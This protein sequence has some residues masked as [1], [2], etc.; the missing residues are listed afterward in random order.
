MKNTEGGCRASDEELV[1]VL[2]EG[3]WTGKT[4]MMTNPARTIQMWR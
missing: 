1:R 2:D 3:W 4:Q